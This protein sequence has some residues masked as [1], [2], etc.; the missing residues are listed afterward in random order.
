MYVLTSVWGQKDRKS[1][2]AEKQL[3]NL[4]EEE[5]EVLGTIWKLFSLKLFQAGRTLKIRNSKFR[6]LQ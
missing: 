4:D 6:I 3:L 5:A 2:V 1:N